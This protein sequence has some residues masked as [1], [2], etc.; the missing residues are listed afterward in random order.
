MTN[1]TCSAAPQVAKNKSV[2]LQIQIVMAAQTLS[3]QG[4]KLQLNGGPHAKSKHLL[5]CMFC[6]VI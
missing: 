1:P 4:A 5:S 6:I 2:V 3:P